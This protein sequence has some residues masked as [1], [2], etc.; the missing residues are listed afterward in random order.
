MSRLLAPLLLALALAL[1]GC[2]RPAPIAIPTPPPA[3]TAAH[4]GP[5][6]PDVPIPTAAGRLER[7]RAETPQG[8]EE[9]IGFAMD[10]SPAEVLGWYRE[11]LLA[12]GWQPQTDTSLNDY[13]YKD[14]CPN[15]GLHI[16]AFVA[17]ATPVHVDLSL[18]PLLCS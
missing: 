1:A 3:P 9:Q 7:A 8:A 15:Y 10:T 17:V 11:E 12:R 18:R 16:D 6:A 4:V 13:V 14:G 2:A 5:P